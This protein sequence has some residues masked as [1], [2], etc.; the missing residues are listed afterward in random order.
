MEHTGQEN[1]YKFGPEMARKSIGSSGTRDP[2][3]SAGE[4][5]VPFSAD[6]SAISFSVFIECRSCGIDNCFDIPCCRVELAIFRGSEDP[7]KCR[8]CHADMDTMLAYC[9]ERV[10]PEIVRREG[11]KC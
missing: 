8:G 11:P 4:Q 7:I 6:L 3:C 1:S 10:G 5:D 9:G 2:Q